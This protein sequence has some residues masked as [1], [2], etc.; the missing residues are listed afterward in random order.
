[1][2]LYSSLPHASVESLQKESYGGEKKLF[3]TESGKYPGGG[4][5]KLNSKSGTIVLGTV[6]CESRSF[7]QN[8]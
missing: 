4:G 7:S 2:A 3:P 8:Q 1:L 6:V 5:K